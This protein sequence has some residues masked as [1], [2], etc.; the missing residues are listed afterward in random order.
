MKP[1]TGEERGQA[2]QE[3]QGRHHDMG[4]AMRIGCFHGS[5]TYPATVSRLAALVL[6]I[7]IDV[8]GSWRSF[9]MKRSNSM[10]DARGMAAVIPRQ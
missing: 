3:L 9:E 8:G 4:R 5:T 2:L 7:D 1:W 10:L 6:E